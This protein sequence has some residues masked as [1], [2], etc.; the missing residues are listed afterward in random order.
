LPAGQYF[1]AA[2]TDFESSDFANEDFVAQFATQSVT[3][4]IRDGE[5][6]TQAIQI[7]R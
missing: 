4:T 2:L 1:L 5:E 3:V 6:T 7:A